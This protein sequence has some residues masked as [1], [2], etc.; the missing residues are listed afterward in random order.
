M[1]LNRALSGASS[2]FVGF[3]K[4]RVS[5]MYLFFTKTP[6]EVVF[7]SFLPINKSL[8]TTSWVLVEILLG[9]SPL[10]G[11]KPHKCVSFAMGNHV[12]MSSLGV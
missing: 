12:T 9:W 2:V 8:K 1:N 3:A 5:E 4:G 10:S 11:V 6:Q 7:G